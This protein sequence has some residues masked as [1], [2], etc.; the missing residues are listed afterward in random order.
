MIIARA[1]AGM[2]FLSHYMAARSCGCGRIYKSV[3]KRFH[4]DET[5]TLS[6]L[7]V[8]AGHY[9]HR[10]IATLLI[11]VLNCERVRFVTLKAV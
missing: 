7:E 4:E 10:V 9:S 6:Q 3:S 11:P 1:R 2:T 8:S 5:V